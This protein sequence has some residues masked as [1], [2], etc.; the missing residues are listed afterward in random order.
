M[1][2]IMK[3]FTGKRKNG[4]NKYDAIL[5]FRLEKS[6]FILKNFKIKGGDFVIIYNRR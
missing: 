5:S 6:Y 1:D 4:L 2:N 3:Y